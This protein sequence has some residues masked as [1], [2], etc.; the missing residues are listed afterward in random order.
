M[1]RQTKVRLKACKGKQSNRYHFRG[2][3]T[4]FRASL[5]CSQT[6]YMITENVFEQRWFPWPRNRN[7][8]RA[9]ELG[10]TDRESFIFRQRLPLIMTCKC[11][12]AKA[13]PLY[14][15][16]Q[17]VCKS[18]WQ[19]GLLNA[20]RSFFSVQNNPAALPLFLNILFFAT[21]SVMGGT[22]KGQRA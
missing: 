12:K 22:G 14:Q 15:I 21:Q 6:G 1:S 9:L 13:I 5:A 16:E 10:M 4:V 2:K 8:H 18:P 7:E 3:V 19:L 20:L 11:Q 17:R